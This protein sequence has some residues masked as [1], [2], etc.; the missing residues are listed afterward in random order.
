LECAGS[1]KVVVAYG[2]GWCWWLRMATEEGPLP[3]IPFSPSTSAYS[4]AAAFSWASLLMK[5][6]V[7]FLSTGLEM[8]LMSFEVVCMVA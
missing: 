8:L 4:G 2:P 3:G 1:T 7:A 5:M 6:L